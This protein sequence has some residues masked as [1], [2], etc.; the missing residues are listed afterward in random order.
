MSS[1]ALKSTIIKS[2]TNTEDTK[3]LKEIQALLKN[4]KDRV[5]N[6]PNEVL[7]EIEMARKQIKKGE[8]KTQEVVEKQFSKWKS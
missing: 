4:K 5:L 8:F 2:I 1:N 3:I 6:I 7:Q